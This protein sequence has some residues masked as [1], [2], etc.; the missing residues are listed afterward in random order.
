MAVKKEIRILLVEDDTIT[1]TVIKRVLEINGYLLAGVASNG[2]EAVKQT[3]ALRPDVI[4]MDILMPDMDGLEATQQIH[5]ECP[6]PV[7]IL[8]SH[9]SEELVEKASRVGASAYLIKPPSP[10]ELDRAIAISMARHNDLME[11]QHVNDQLTTQK[12]TLEKALEE[13]KT[14]RGFLPICARCKKIKDVKGYWRQVED[15]IS[16]HT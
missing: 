16:E 14:L 3:I 5:K 11:L 15:Y 2:R 12:E 8:T 7:V 13:I 6:T 10:S 9:K 1:M 4:L